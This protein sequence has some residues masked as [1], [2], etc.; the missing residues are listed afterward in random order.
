MLTLIAA[1]G[2]A[3]TQSALVA[4]M[5]LGVVGAA[6]ASASDPL[7]KG[8][9][10]VTSLG[11]TQMIVL[12]TAAALTVLAVRRRWRGALALLLAVSMTE[13]AVTLVKEFVSRPRPPA[14]DAVVHAAGF[15]FPSGH[16]AVSAA[17]YATLAFL[18]VRALH[19]RARIAVIAS[20]AL[21]VLAVGASRIYLGAHYL[22]DV[23]AGWLTGGVF[24][25]VAWA[26]ALR[27]QSPRLRTLRD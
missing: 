10:A 13:L 9:L 21:L 22:T 25:I 2:V 3:V 8:M 5:D 6:H 19:G 4:R 17:V 18:L 12:V 11:G 14:D 23:A 15:S 27:V 26:L 7:T 1:L 24:A 20:G 16:A